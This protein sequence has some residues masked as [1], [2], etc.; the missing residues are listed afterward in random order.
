MLYIPEL[1]RKEFA[2]TLYNYEASYHSLTL[3]NYEALR[4]QRIKIKQSRI[5]HLN[6]G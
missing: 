6:P 4:K 1:Q 2:S 3:L 5:L